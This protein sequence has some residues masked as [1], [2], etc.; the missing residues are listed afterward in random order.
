MIETI[1]NTVATVDDTSVTIYSNYLQEKTN[2]HTI[3]YTQPIK[4]TKI[5]TCGNIIFIVILYQDNYVEIW[6]VDIDSNSTCILFYKYNV[7]GSCV[8]QVNIVFNIS[9]YVQNNN[10]VF[11]SPQKYTSNIIENVANDD[12]YISKNM[13]YVVS[14]N[15]NIV[16][17]TKMINNTTMYKKKYESV[18]IV[19]INDNDEMIILDNYGF[20][21]FVKEF[22]R[23]ERVIEIPLWNDRK[24]EYLFFNSSFISTFIDKYYDK[25]VYNVDE[26]QNIYLKQEKIDFKNRNSCILLWW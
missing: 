18:Y 6:Q 4:H 17:C 21:T 1:R 25:I 13:S 10:I 23:E 11:Y 16:Y 14:S 24:Y 22:G 3:N 26:Y 19:D 9:M 5:E 2:I 15:N 7:P 8:N 12:V 20:L